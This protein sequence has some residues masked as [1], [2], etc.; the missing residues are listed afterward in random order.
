MLDTDFA[1]FR[2]WPSLA[3]RLQRVVL[4]RLPTPVERLPS[5]ICPS[6]WVKRDDLSGEPYG[7]NKLRKLELLLADA[8]RLGARRVITAGAAGSHHALATLVYGKRLGFEVSLVLFPQKRTERVV[9]TLLMDQGLGAE[10]RF[11]R[12]METVPLA[13]LA[14]RW[15]HRH[16][17]TYVIPPGGSNA[18]GTIG[19]VNAALE[20]A[21]QVEAGALRGPDVVHVAA[22]TLGTAAGIA[23]GLHLAGVR[24]RVAAYR[25]TGA[26]VC[27]R[28]LLTRLVREAAGVLAE[29][30]AD[31]ADVEAVVHSTDLIAGQL[32]AGYGLETPAGMEAE[33]TL[34]EAGVRLDPT[35]TA[36]AAA[37]FLASARREPGAIHL[38]WHTLSAVEP[39]SAAAGVT[40][41]DLPAPFRAYLER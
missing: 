12:R 13:V 4:A 10:L 7:G 32:G 25:I 17:S 18:L 2:R 41:E 38:F 28:H 5:E 40:P 33:S 11:T 23:L 6:G 8:Q 22:G 29:G 9:R 20:L 15:A 30:G 24:A 35:Y 19:Y 26:I 31:S 3:S 16:E 39:A 21:E 34:R 27:N 37:G 36:K 14:A 1:L